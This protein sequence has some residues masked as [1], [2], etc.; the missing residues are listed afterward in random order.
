ML[1]ASTVF[2]FVFL[3]VVLLLYYTVFRKWR[4]GQNI[5]LLIASLIFYAWG[6]PKYVLIMIASIIVT[7]A[8]GLL[9]DK[10]RHRKVLS[11]LV[12]ALTAVLNLSV[13]FIFKYL[14]F[15]VDNINSIAGL[16]LSVPNIAFL[17]VSV[18]LLCKQ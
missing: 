14:M 11:R 6:E 4:M 9:V 8:L 13:L 18:S 10:V 16:N 12:I 15:T 1:F 3:P 5:M 2:I 7:Y 17:L